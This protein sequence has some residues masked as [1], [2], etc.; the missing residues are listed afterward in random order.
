MHSPS[1]TLVSPAVGC[2]QTTALRRAADTRHQNTTQN[3]TPNTN[4]TLWNFARGNI[5]W[6]KAARALLG[7]D[8]ADSPSAQA[9]TM[10]TNEYASATRMQML[11]CVAEYIRLNRLSADLRK[12][13]EAAIEQADYEY[14]YGMP[15]RVRHLECLRDQH[16]EQLKNSFPKTTRREAGKLKNE[17]DSSLTQ[18]STE[19]RF[20]YKLLSE[21]LAIAAKTDQRAGLL[22]QLRQISEPLAEKTVQLTDLTG[23]AL[24]LSNQLAEIEAT[25]EVELNLPARL[26]LAFAQILIA[27]ADKTFQIQAL[28]VGKAMYRLSRTLLREVA[29]MDHSLLRTAEFVELARR[30]GLEDVVRLS[31][32]D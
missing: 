25:L 20:R 10:Q 28:T 32:E 2:A 6:A 8:Y 12:R 31:Q 5:N 22:L 3:T 30:L 1:M 29:Y 23:D 9:G 13:F 16:A 21:L 18:V 17:I 7:S 4:R 14:S 19:E 27:E 11:D 26:R 24:E 15:L